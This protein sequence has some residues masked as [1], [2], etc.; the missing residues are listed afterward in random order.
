[1]EPEVIVIIIDDEPIALP[2]DIVDVLVN[3]DDEQ[4]DIYL[5]SER[6]RKKLKKVNMC[7]A[8]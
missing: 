3:L 6:V 4:R 1:M 5:Q 8:T 2:P 7:V